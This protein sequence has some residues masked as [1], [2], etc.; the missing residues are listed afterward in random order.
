[1][2]RSAAGRIVAACWLSFCLL[3]ITSYIASLVAL[4]IAN[5]TN[6]SKPVIPFKTF[7]QMLSQTE[8]QY[9]VTDPHQILGEMKNSNDEMIQKIYKSINWALSSS[10]IERGLESIRNADG[11]VAQ[12]VDVLEL[13]YYIHT[14]GCEDIVSVGENILRESYGFACNTKTDSTLIC[15]SLSQALLELRESGDMQLLSSKWLRKD[16]CPRTTAESYI[17]AQEVTL[18][19]H[20]P[21]TVG[22][23]AIAWFLLLIGFVLGPLLLLIEVCIDRRRNKVRVMSWG[24]WSKTGLFRHKLSRKK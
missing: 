13:S 7:Q 6:P 17:S 18:L 23:T 22:E 2:P 20:E 14:H 10:S 4:V 15:N 9:G 24:K 8:V 16:N 5:N 19:K 12:I 1:M 21:L 3:L 11:D